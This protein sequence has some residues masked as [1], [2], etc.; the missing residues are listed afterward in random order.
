VGIGM[1]MSETSTVKIAFRFPA[2]KS[3][4]DDDPSNPFSRAVAALMRDNARLPSLAQAFLVTQ[5]P[6]ETWR[7]FGVFVKSAGGRVLLFP[8]IKTE[9]V[10]V[11]GSRGRERAFQRPFNFD[12]A[13]LERD[14]SSWHITTPGSTEHQGKIPTVSLGE[15]RVLW[16][17]LGFASPSILREVMTETVA[18]F[19]VPAKSDRWKGN[20]FIKARENRE[21]P[22][23]YMPPSIG[24]DAGP[25]FPWIS[26]IVG[27]MGFPTYTGSDWANPYGSEFVD[28]ATPRDKAMRVSHDRFALDDETDIQK[29]A[30]WAPGSL[31]IPML[32]ATPEIGR[33]NGGPL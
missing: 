16:F 20:E 11:R 8:G 15:G 29:S 31:R 33:E 27:S 1:S 24:P 7:W 28:E 4:T 13:S 5:E 22:G 23:I 6:E 17:G 2:G 32:M 19:E 14:R 18:T 10:H 30:L 3:G 21:F 26:I 12:H 9:L 25:A